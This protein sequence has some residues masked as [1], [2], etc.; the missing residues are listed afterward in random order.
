MYVILAIT[1]ILLILVSAAT[2]SALI[3]TNCLFQQVLMCAIS[4]LSNLTTDYAAA[5]AYLR[6]NALID[7]TYSHRAEK[8]DLE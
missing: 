4:A 2:Q 8:L 5:A 7:H 3:G 6:Q 1:A